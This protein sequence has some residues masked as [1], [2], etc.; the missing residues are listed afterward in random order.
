MINWLGTRAEWYE[1]SMKDHVWQQEDV[2]KLFLEGVRGAIPFTASQMDVV[3]RIVRKTLPK[4]EGMLDLG[5]GDGILGRAV[6][7]EYPD[8]SGVFLD[9]PE[10]MIGNGNAG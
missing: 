6:L 3:L 5:C 2:A 4:I 7:A 10:P 1:E 9:F 8:A